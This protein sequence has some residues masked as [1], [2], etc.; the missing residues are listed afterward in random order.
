M[1]M[2]PKRKQENVKESEKGER[3]G[4]IRIL[5]SIKAHACTPSPIEREAEKGEVDFTDIWR[6]PPVL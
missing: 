4:E 1:E 3:K 6:S 5:I 2:Q